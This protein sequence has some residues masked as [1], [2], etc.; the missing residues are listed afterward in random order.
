MKNNVQG[1]ITFLAVVVLA[2]AAVSFVTDNTDVDA[3]R[4]DATVTIDSVDYEYNTEANRWV[5]FVNLGG[6]YPPVL[7]V[8]TIVGPSANISFT[9]NIVDGMVTYF[10][11]TVGSYLSGGEYRITM[12]IAGASASATYVVLGSVS[13]SNDSVEVG[14][15]KDLSVLKDPVNPSEP[16]LVWESSDVSVATVSSAGKVTGVSVGTV[17]ITAKSTENPNVFGTCTVTVTEPEKY[18]IIASAGNGGSISPA[19]NVEVIPGENQA[20]RITP[21]SGYSMSALKVDGVS[22]PVSSDYIFENVHNYHTISV[23]FSAAV[24]PTPVLKYNIT[25]TAETGG[26]ISPARMSVPSGSSATFLISADAG[27]KINK[28]MLDGTVDVTSQVTDG[29]YVISNVTSNHTVNVSFK[30]STHVDVN[31]EVGEH[32]KISPSGENLPIGVDQEFTVTCDDGYSI[33][34]VIVNGNEVSVTGGKFTVNVAEDTSV[35]VTLKENSKTPAWIF[36]VVGII[37]I[38]I[39]IAVVSYVRKVKTV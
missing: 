23:T 36:I 19:G 26:S 7:G 22:V 11:N 8:M 17:T 24:P 31:I 35:V 30:S 38:I 2:A 33:D 21:N 27:M 1:L 18:V 34:K 14:K 4:I 10:G 29:K 6:S 13:L 9:P 3:S 32:G 39:V 12:G 37:A 15:S 28:V 20:F 16:G 5:M 25:A